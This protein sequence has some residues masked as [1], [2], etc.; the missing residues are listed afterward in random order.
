[1]EL[2]MC[3]EKIRRQ[4]SGE[5]RSAR[6]EYVWGMIRKNRAMILKAELGWLALLRSGLARGQRGTST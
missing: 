3:K 4:E 2:A 1:L 5:G 6:A